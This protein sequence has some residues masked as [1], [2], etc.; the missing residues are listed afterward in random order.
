[1]VADKPD[2]DQ[3][4]RDAE[5]ARA[6]L[7]AHNKV[8]AEAKLKPL[9]S[10]PVLTAAALAHAEDMAKH[11]VMRHEGSD[12]ST[13]AQRL[14]RLNYAYQNMAENVS[15]GQET[16]EAVMETWMTSP[17]HR[18]NILGDFE[19]AGVALARDADGVPYWCV[20][21]AT[22][23][24]ELDPKS[25]AAEVVD[26]VNKERAKAGKP[27]L[28]RDP[29]L[30][31]LA[32]SEAK[33]LSSLEN[34]EQY[35]KRGDELDRAIKKSGYRFRKLYELGASGVP[36]PADV[37]ASWM[38]E[39][40]DRDHLLSDVSEVGV[41]YARNAKGIPFWCLILARPLGK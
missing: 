2:A 8:R 13:P 18:K 16:V 22:P 40:D 24:H 25:A 1:M 15:R 31:S 17:P 37:V 34:A 23:W 27:A 32:A 29:R 12:G 35:P 4:K 14:Q 21:F 5:L 3:V 36:Q 9:E 38:K 33:S 41:G 10:D 11:G 20:E 6:V 30:A 7:E 26:L 19:K 39:P 28:K